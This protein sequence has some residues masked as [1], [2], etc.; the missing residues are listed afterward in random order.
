MPSGRI[1]DRITLWTLPWL[2]T[3]VFWQTYS[4]NV[5]LLIVGGFLFGGLMFGPDLD[6][7]SRH[8]KRWGWFRWVWLPYQKSLRHRSFLSHGPIIGTTLRLIYLFCVVCLFW[9]LLL[10]FTRDILNLN[11]NWEIAGK[12]IFHYRKEFFT[13]FLGMELGAMSHYL[14]DWTSSVYKD[15]KKKGIYDWLSSGKIKKH[16]ISDRT[17]KLP[18]T[19]ISESRSRIK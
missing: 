9:F 13:L 15:L 4:G 18:Q 11:W 10:L 1:H 19:K 12:S 2:A 16:K 5:T 3:I 17:N 14:I 6:I 8:Y 7:Y